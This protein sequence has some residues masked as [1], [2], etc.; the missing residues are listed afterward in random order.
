MVLRLIFL[1]IFE[2]KFIF[3]RSKSKFLS[4][5]KSD[6]IFSKAFVKT[7][8]PSPKDSEGKKFIRFFRNCPEFA[9]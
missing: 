2:R 9:L 6:E 8:L 5:G 1:L 4:S 3:I 7:A